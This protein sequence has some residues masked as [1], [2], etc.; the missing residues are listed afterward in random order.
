MPFPALCVLLFAFSTR[1]GA[2]DGRVVDASGAPVAGA[3]VAILGH[4]SGARTDLGGYFRWTPDPLPPFEILVVLSGG[5]YMAPFYVSELPD[6]VLIVTVEPLLSEDVVVTSGAAPN[7]DA[8]PASATATIAREDI[9]TR[10]PV[11]LT[12]VIANLPGAGSLSDLHTS[13]PSLRGLARGRTLLLIDGARVTTERRAGPSASFVDPFFLDGVEVSRGPGSVGYGSDAFG[14]VIHARTRRVESR[15][16]T[17]VRARGALGAGLPEATAGVE[18]THGLDRGGVVVQ[19]RY[20][21]FENY[22]TPEGEIHNSQASDRGFLARVTHELGDGELSAGWQTSLGRDV[23]R[24]DSRGEAVTT[25][26]P[27]EDSNRLTL[28]YDLEPRAGFTRIGFEG[29][30]GRYQLVTQR[31]EMATAGTPASRAVGDVTADDFSFRSFGVRPVGS[32][33]WEMGVDVNG[34]YGL[35]ARNVSSVLTEDGAELDE[36]AIE[37]A[38]RADVGLYTSTEILLSPKWSL[39]AGARVDHV[40]T[41]NEGGLFGDRSTSNA[42]LSGYGSLT[43]GLARGLSLTGQL[44]H[45]F[46]DPTLSDRYFHG[47][48]GRGVVTGNPNLE[49]ERANQLDAALRF[50]RAKTRW[51]VYGY[52]YRFSNLIERFESDQDLFFFRNRGRA[53]IRGFEVEMLSELGGKVTLEVSA[54]IARGD[55][56]DDGGSIDDIPG[57][58]LKFQLRRGLA[59]RG[60]AELGVALFVEDDLPGPT[61]IVTPRYATMDL[62]GGWRLS[63]NVELRGLVRNLFDSAYPVSPDARAVLAPGINA[64]VTVVAE[65]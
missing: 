29:F 45:G 55:T 16:P 60:Y 39:G 17:R 49:P 7:I 18:L 57:A 26:Y 58:N 41:N 63:K 13:V 44:A 31:D 32:A 4:P 24:P 5:N 65:F 1:A 12:E 22:R 48:S 50:V 38:R 51:A 42:A 25:S 54:Q 34:R 43:V 62:S 30:W 53:D 28:S 61:E 37:S 36:L 21:N 27:E 56:R 52:F 59:D 3:E 20:R 47:V 19:A 33:R 35:E 23:G 40:T 9:E 10:H 46:R 6:G 64:V 11:T 8:T 14:G 2:F 15:S